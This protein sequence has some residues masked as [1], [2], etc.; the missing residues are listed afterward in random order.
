MPRIIVA[1]LLVSACLVL[2]CT[3]PQF[4]NG[5]N[6]M[7]QT[8]ADYTDCYSKAALDAFTPPY[9]EDAGLKITDDSTACMEARGY[10][11]KMVC[12]Q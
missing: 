6:N 1:T 7:A 2:G 11:P 3:K 4:S 8:E 5:Q 12:T 10:E 9:P